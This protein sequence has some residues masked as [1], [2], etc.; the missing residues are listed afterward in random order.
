M[1]PISE[2]LSN[3][4]PDSHLVGQETVDGIPTVWLARGEVREA[5]RFLKEQV[6]QPYEMLYD[7]SAIDERVREH[8]N[9]QPASDFTVVYHLLSIGRNEDLRLKV[10]LGER[11][12]SVPTI[13]DIYPNA[14]WYEREVWDLFGV[15]FDGHPH[16]TR[17]IMPP[18]WEGHPLR[19]DQPARG[20]EMGLYTL[21]DADQDRE[22]AALQFRPEDWGM[23][24]GNDGTD[25][26]FLNIG[27]NHPSA[28][29]VFRVVVQIDGEEIIDAVPDIGYHHRAAEK[30]GERQSWHTFI[31]Y[32]DR[33]DYLGGV[34]NN[35]PYVMALEKLAGIKVPDRVKVVRVMLCEL[36][37]IMSHLLF[38]GTFVQDLGAM[39]PIFFMFVDRQR[40]YDI[41]EAIC[42]FRMHPA[43]FRIGG[44]SQ[45]LPKG[46]DRL[47]REFLDWMP[48][49]LD[50]YDQLMMK[51]RTVKMRTKDVGVYNTE[52]ALDWG[53]TGPGLR[54]T[55]LEWDYRK[56][57]PYSGYDQFE[58]DIPIAHNGDCY[59]RCAVRVEEMRQSLRIIR[60]CLENM[61]EGEHKARHPKTTPP[62]KPDH[63]MHDIETLIHHFLNV[64]WGPVM[65]VGE[66]SAAVEATKGVNSYYLVSDGSTN[67]YRTRIRTPSFPHLQMIPHISRGH[68]IPDLIAILGSIDFVMA[69]VDR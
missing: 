47:V 48:S 17:L 30:M 1:Q 57:R 3:A 4:F 15:S 45:D 38:Y 26:M 54:A 42:G 2:E 37:R 44:L 6:K 29:G 69:D 35:L 51:N 23:Q 21:D 16:L 34:M 66:V 5:I 27:P 60:Q 59:D 67:S 64:S 7:L 24:R 65:P 55:G 18:T 63:T 32:T 53:V 61:P 33:I 19:K 22:Q 52:E 56:K 62:L 36:F 14:N 50:E 41:I 49:R 68:M 11:D 9:G 28:H 43:W 31:P 10:G 8:R 12:L 13:S 46:W 58:F 20:T 39:S 40:V 25:F